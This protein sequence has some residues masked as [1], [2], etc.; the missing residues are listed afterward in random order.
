MPKDDDWLLD[1]DDPPPFAFPKE[2]VALVMEREADLP[3]FVRLRPDGEIET[4]SL[5]EDPP[6][7]FF[8]EEGKP[9]LSAGKKLEELYPGIL[10]QAFRRPLDR[11]TLDF[12]YQVAFDNLEAAGLLPKERDCQTHH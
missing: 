6:A 9:V 10:L 5:L 4:L 3:V 12:M 1:L 8:Y 11:E 7:A 2:N